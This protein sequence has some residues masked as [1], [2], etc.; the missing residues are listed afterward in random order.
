MRIIA[1][2]SVVKYYEQHP[3]TETG[4]KIWYKLVNQADWEKP[5]DVLEVFRNARPIGQDRVIFKINNNDHRL[6][7]HVNYQRKSVYIC[8]IG[9]HQE[10][11]KI[12]ALTVWNY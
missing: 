8:F 9:T 5:T 6:I 1:K 12:D 2:A 3:S 7:V 10:Y 4:L 11:D